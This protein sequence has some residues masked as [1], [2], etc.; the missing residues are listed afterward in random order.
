MSAW[1]DIVMLSQIDMMRGPIAHYL[2]D[3]FGF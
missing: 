3:A 2:R 1:S